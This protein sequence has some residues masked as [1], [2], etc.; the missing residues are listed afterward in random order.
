MAKN[1]TQAPDEELE[2]V[3]LEKEWKSYQI[4]MTAGDHAGTH[5]M[6]I[7]VPA[8][9]DLGETINGVIM[10]H[11]NCTAIDMRSTM[12]NNELVD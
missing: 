6:D 11:L 10:K 12:V 8:S 5:C 4:F 7:I 2:T 3:A 1:K 9:W